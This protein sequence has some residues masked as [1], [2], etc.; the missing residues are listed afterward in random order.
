MQS[1]IGIAALAPLFSKSSRPFKV[2]LETTDGYAK[3]SVDSHFDETPLRRFCLPQ[4]S[5]PLTVC[6]A[7]LPFENYRETFERYSSRREGWRL[8]DF[9]CVTA[10]GG[11]Q[12]V[13]DLSSL[14]LLK[15]PT[16]A[17]RGFEASSHFLL[18][19]TGTG[20][21]QEASDVVSADG[22]VKSVVPPTRTTLRASTGRATAFPST[23]AARAIVL[24]SAT[25]IGGEPTAVSVTRAGAA[26]F[27][28]PA[29]CVCVSPEFRST[30][31]VLDLDT[32]RRRKHR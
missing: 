26:V 6:V 1:S 7:P 9:L 29:C 2:L 19:G 25:E 14:Y 15:G 12:G 13:S 8:R 20:R 11:F 3:N 24:S 27:L 23:S 18:I 16:L 30:S 22:G 5:P 28:F 4:L 32:H 10:P 31:A 21:T 17:R